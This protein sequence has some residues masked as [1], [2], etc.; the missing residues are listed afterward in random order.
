MFFALTG[1]KEHDRGHSI[2]FLENIYI[3]I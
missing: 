1:F 3:L 2:T